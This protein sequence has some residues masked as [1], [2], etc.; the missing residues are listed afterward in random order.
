MGIFRR[1]IE[2]ASSKPGQPS[3][4]CRGNSLLA[5]YSVPVALRL[6]SLRGWWESHGLCS[7]ELPRTRSLPPVPLFGRL[8]LQRPPPQALCYE[9][10]L[11]ELP[12]RRALRTWV[13]L[14]E[15]PYV[16]TIRARWRPI[17]FHWMYRARYAK[18]YSVT[19]KAGLSNRNRC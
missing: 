17:S 12:L 3:R 11:V 14:N 5:Q 15:Q 13:R 6:A 4:Y 7:R 10:F 2:P 18:F 9:S 8:L 19:V 16:K 1:G